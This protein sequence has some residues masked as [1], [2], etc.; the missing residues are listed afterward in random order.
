MA[1]EKVK[2]TF[3]GWRCLHC[4]H[5]WMPRDTAFRSKDERPNKCPGCGSQNWDRPRQR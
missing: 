2:V 3:D 1:T 5:E 4:G